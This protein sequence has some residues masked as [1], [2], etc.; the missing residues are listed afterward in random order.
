M[1]ERSQFGAT[2]TPMAILV[3]EVGKIASALAAAAP[4]VL[5]LAGA[6]QKQDKPA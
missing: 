5:A 3:D 2:G 6:P 1:S 4:A